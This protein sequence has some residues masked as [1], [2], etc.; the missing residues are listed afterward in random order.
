MKLH[1]AHIKLREISE[2]AP[3]TLHPFFKKKQ[4][5]TNLLE[6]IQRIGILTPPILL[7][8]DSPNQFDILCGNQRI[9]V[10]KSLEQEDTLCCIMEANCSAEHLLSL[11]LE[12]QI[13]QGQLSI[14]EQAY[15]VN[16]CD[17]LLIE[18]KRKN[19]FLGSLPANTIQYGENFLI[20]LCYLP[21]Q[22]QLQLHASILSE[23][24]ITDL[25]Q[26]PDKEKI[27][28]CGIIEDLK[29][30]SNYQRKLLSYVSD[31]Q[32]RQN[33][34][35]EEL[36][37]QLGIQKIVSEEKLTR[38]QKI[39]KLFIH[40]EKMAHPLLMEAQRQFSKEISKLELPHS[41]QVTPSKSFE[42]DEI[43]LTITF[44]DLHTLKGVWQKFLQFIPK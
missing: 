12:D 10:L 4:I 7:T 32:K 41:C 20:P 43:T 27:R 24:I 2:Q 29:L 42:K 38:K 39:E 33:S 40:L 36:A 5:N 37:E 11:I 19:S 16:I 25:Q 18:R 17:T 44:K 14:M 21:R 3:Y 1:F 26:F 23:K 28:L 22:I 31:L 8:T 9:H 35:F 13:R 34:T 30:G 15:F 6:S